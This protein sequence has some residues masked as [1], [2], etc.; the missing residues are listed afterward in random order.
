[1]RGKFQDQG[2]CHV[3]RT[4]VDDCLIDHQE[5]PRKISDPF[6]SFHLF[7]S[8]PAMTITNYCDSSVQWLDSTLNKSSD[9]VMTINAL[10]L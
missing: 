3:H 10:A 7:Y 2:A 8:Y 6:F 1:M 4:Q 9:V 5:Q